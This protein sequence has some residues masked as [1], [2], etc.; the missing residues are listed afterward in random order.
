[1]PTWA[2]IVLGFLGSAGFWATVQ[3]LITRWDNNKGLKKQLKKLE[4]DGCRTQLLL[5]MSDYPGERQEILTLAQY[6][7]QNLQGNFYLD[8]L[9]AEWLERNKLKRPSWFKPRHKLNPIEG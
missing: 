9:F 4:K 1:M 2:A 5:L 3:F 8:N 7:F 6:Y